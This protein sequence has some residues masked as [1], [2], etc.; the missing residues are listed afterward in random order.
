MDTAVSLPHAPLGRRRWRKELRPSSLR[1]LVNSTPLLPHDAAINEPVVARELRIARHTSAASPWLS[2]APDAPI[3]RRS[4]PTR[5]VPAA[6]G[7]GRS[8]PRPPT[9]PRCSPTTSAPSTARSTWPARTWRRCGTTSA[10]P[11]PRMGPG[12]TS[13]RAGAPMG[14]GPHVVDQLHASQRRPSPRTRRTACGRLISLHVA[15]VLGG[16]R[17]G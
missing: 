5:T 9:A 4:E 2:M 12:T 11:A 7:S 16:L 3:F 17:H 10:S 1:E 15:H 13:V 6:D 14:A 8:A